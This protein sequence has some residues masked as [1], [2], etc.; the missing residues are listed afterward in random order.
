[1]AR[2]TRVRDAQGRRRAR[3]ATQLAR[4]AV[5][6]PAV[7]PGH[8]EQFPLV[9]TRAAKGWALQLGVGRGGA[10]GTNC[11][12]ASFAGLWLSALLHSFAEASTRVGRVVL[13][14]LVSRILA[15]GLNQNVSREVRCGECIF[16]RVLL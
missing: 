9:G 1:M 10:R 5:A 13:C 14:E 4:G 16:Y 11:H 12:P 6:V 8:A 7:E 3:Y 15:C 2:H